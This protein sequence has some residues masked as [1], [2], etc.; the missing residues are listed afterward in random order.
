MADYDKSRKER[1]KAEAERE[2]REEER[3]RK[4]EEKKEVWLLKNTYANSDWRFK[5]TSNYW[6]QLH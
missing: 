5:G 2:R 4:E 1:M 3:K 6:S